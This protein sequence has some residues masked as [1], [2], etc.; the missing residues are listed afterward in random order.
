MQVKPLLESYKTLLQQ[1]ANHLKVITYDIFK[2][3]PKKEHKRLTSEFVLNTHPE[4]LE[5]ISESYNP[6]FVS[7]YIDLAK[8]LLLSDHEALKK[9][10]VKRI[11][12]SN[13]E[14]VTE[15]VDLLLDCALIYETFKL[16]FDETIAKNLVENVI[17]AYHKSPRKTNLSESK[18]VLRKLKLIEG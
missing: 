18:D 16:A 10:I 3:I 4:E 15:Y 5:I 17:E 1:L 11:Q 7:V 14:N 6:D 13:A 9:I 8:Q 2:L 12:E